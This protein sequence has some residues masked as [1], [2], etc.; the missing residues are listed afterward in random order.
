[1]TKREGIKGYENFKRRCVEKAVEMKKK[2]KKKRRRDQHKLNLEIQK[3]RRIIEW[4]EN[5]RIA[6]E[7]GR[8]IKRWKRGIKMLR[9]SNTPKWMQKKVSE[10]TSL[11]EVEEKAANHLDKLIEE[12][13]EGD[14]RKNRL[15]KNI[16]MLREVQE[17]ERG[18]RNFFNKLKQAHRREEIFA[19]IEVEVNKD[20]DEKIET[21]RTEK[22]DIQRV[23]TNFY[24]DLWKKRRV[25]LRI[26]QQMIGKITKKLTEIEKEELDKKLTIE[27]LKK[28]TKMMKKGKATGIDGIP[29]EFYQ[30]FEFVTEWLYELYGEMIGR[31]EMTET[32]KMSIV[33][34]IYKKGDKK[35]I[36]NYRPISLLTADYKILAKTLTE[37]LKKVLTKLIGSEQQGFIPGGDIAG[38][39][40]LV[41]EIIAHCDEEDMEGILIMM[42]FMK[43]YDRVDRETMME[44]MK[45]MNI[46]ENFRTMVHLLYT[47]SMATVVAN[48]EMGEKFRTE[49]GVRQGCPLSPLLFIIV[50][51][52]LAIDL[53]ESDE[54]EGIRM[55][56]DAN[57]EVNI[58]GDKTKSEAQQDSKESVETKE[59]RTDEEVHQEK[60]KAMLA[61]LAQ[62][63]ADRDNN[64]NNNRTTTTISSHSHRQKQEDTED[65]KISMYAD[66]SSTFIAQV[67][68]TGKARE[69]INNYER[70][71][72]G[73]LHDG[74]TI[75]MKLGRTRRRD[76]TRKQLGVDFKVMSEED[77]ENYLGDVIGHGVTDEERY[78]E[79]LTKIEATGRKWNKEGIGIYGRAIVAN[80]ILLSK[81]SHRAQINTMSDQIRKKL[82]EKFKDFMWKE[83]GKGM[84]RWE[85][86]PM[87]EEEGGVGLRDPICA[88]DAA[89]I[90]MFVDLMTKDRQPWMKWIER[91]LNRLAEKWGV[92]EA[93]AAKPNKTQLK[94]LKEDCIV[95]ST[96][97]IW[98][99]IGGK[100]GGR[101]KEERKE[102]GELREIELGGMGVNEEKGGWI[103]IERLTT[104][105]AY[106]RLIRTRMKIRNY[107]PKKAHR[108]IH[109]IQRKL[110]AK[111]RD[112]WWR[113]IH[114]VIQ[115]KVRESKWKKNESGE[116]ETRKCPVCK[117]EEEDW[118]HYDYDCK[119]VREMNKNVAE[120]V[121]RA[122]AFSRS[123]WSLE[124]EEMEEKVMLTVAKA[125]WIYH[126]ERVKMDIKKKRRLETKT[127]M[128]RLN[129]RMTAV[130]LI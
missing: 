1:M 63:I 74:K 67:E 26:R 60:L 22:A 107:E 52:L 85:I 103:P 44:T 83:A 4:T 59:A 118:N 18:T 53:R 36:E 61:M 56:K 58:K 3:I 19:L 92:Q 21:E 45:M 51:E 75:L 30:H 16:E 117:T 100:G 10:I 82:K 11:A 12:R 2:K 129:R 90:R 130:A 127:L 97:K 65:D 71:T 122:H 104:K 14:A 48:G 46:G 128:N 24:K 94:E 33:K 108:A 27:E 8:K 79:I 62:W 41:K 5:A 95:E 25:T 37:R 23:A 126:C 91:K 57:E 76:I 40:L 66:D 73:K 89:K 50:L 39:L 109:G 49:G 113:L 32:M 15:E 68:K 31:G 112:Y 88:L 9:E 96:L 84:V 78:E 99:E 69:I 35:R 98:F 116:N 102:M 105:Q 111:E 93:M 77:R 120:S 43:A 54:I 86:L 34:I 110:T 87:K 101:L 80:T 29:A 42:D 64:N 70:S 7:A 38:N 119:G 121:G 55:R 124:E 20:T 123:E 81:I 28:T 72:S 125:R 17:E 115:T 47:R 6:Q 13:D 106:D 114:R